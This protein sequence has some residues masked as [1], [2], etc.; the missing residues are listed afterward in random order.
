MWRS[1]PFLNAAP[2]AFWENEASAAA[3]HRGR[4]CC[5][6]AEFN[7][8]THTDPKT[9]TS[10]HLGSRVAEESFLKTL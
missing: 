1:H 2:Q 7:V 10:L 3:T 4:R 6:G 5:C 9:L 8:S